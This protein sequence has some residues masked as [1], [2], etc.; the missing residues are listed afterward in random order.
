[1]AYD[2]LESLPE[3]IKGTL[4]QPAQ[5]I[6]MA[7]FNS[8]SSDGLGEDNAKDVAWNSVRNVFE[9]DESG[10]WH[11]KAENRVHTSPKGTMPNS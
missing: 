9:Q 1:M 5:Q 4:P 10:E 6:Y 7:A 11:Y 8:A 2:T 3:D